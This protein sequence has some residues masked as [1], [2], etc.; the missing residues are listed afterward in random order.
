MLSTLRFG[1]NASQDAIRRAPVLGVATTLSIAAAL[2]ICGAFGAAV[3]NLEQLL[4]HWGD[5]DTVHVY[6]EH[7]SSPDLWQAARETLSALPGT[8]A[9]HLVA[10]ADAYARLEQQGP[11]YKTLMDGIDPLLLPAS[12]EVK[13]TT[14]APALA[15]TQHLAATA[16]ALPSVESVDYGERE[17]VRLRSLVALIRYAG[18][19]VWIGIGLAGALL[20]ANTIRLTIAVRQGEIELMRLLGA[21][22]TFISTPFLA[23]GL[24]WGFLGGMLSSL[25]LFGSDRYLAARLTHSLADITGGTPVHLYAPSLFWALCAMGCAMGLVGSLLALGHMMIDEPL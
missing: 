11:A 17:L 18:T 10:P 19:A 13:L 14:P 16:E 22:R 23:E 15:V 5:A 1:L 3:N 2:F 12:L 20:V 25:A 4:T 24:V 9:V 8:K 7:G 21:T 6:F